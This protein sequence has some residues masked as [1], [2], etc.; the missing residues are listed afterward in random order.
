MRVENMRSAKGNSIP[1]QFIVETEKGLYFQSYHS[2]IA[3]KPLSGPVQLDREKWDYSRT[4]A[5]YRNLFLGETSKE[6]L[7]KIRTG[8]YI[9]VDLN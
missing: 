8:E 1:N 4:T 9:L 5:K 7:E 2:V 6:T 3:F